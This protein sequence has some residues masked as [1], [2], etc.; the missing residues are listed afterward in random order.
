LLWRKKLIKDNTVD[1][2]DLKTSKIGRKMSGRMKF[3]II[4]GF[5]GLETLERWKKNNHR[6][7]RNIGK[8]EVKENDQKE[9]HMCRSSSVSEIKQSCQTNNNNEC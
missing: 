8:H 7:A 2:G 1:N 3:R 6:K 4:H 5:S 9:D